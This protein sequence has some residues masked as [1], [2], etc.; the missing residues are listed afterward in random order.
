MQGI[1]RLAPGVS[2]AA[3]TADL[4]RISRQIFPVWQS[5]FQDAE[6][7]LTPVPLRE[8]ILGSAPRQVAL[9]GGAV[10]LL[11]LIAIANVA[12]LMLV[13]ASARQPELA[14]RAALGASRL[15]LARLVLVE[16]LTLAGLAGL[17]GW[18]LA[19]L[20]V[21][22]T[23]LVAPALPRI[24]EAV[25][26]G[27]ALAFAGAAWLASGILIA[28]SP[29]AAVLGGVTGRAALA[30]I[31]R[32][33]GGRRAAGIRGTLVVVEFALALPLLLGAGLLLR[34][35]MGLER[36]DP[37]FDPTGVV[38]AELAPPASRY[39]G[40]DEVGRFW[41]GVEAR[42]GEADGVAAAGLA[43]MLP[44]DDYGNS[45][46]N[47]DLRDRPVPEGSSQPTAPWAAV[48]SGYFRALSIPLLQGRLF[49]EADSAAAPP[50]A[51]VSRAGPV[52]TSRAS[53]C[54]DASSSRAAAG[55]ARPP[56]WWGWSAT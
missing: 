36:V 35:V 47:F 7:R 53:G 55:L 48:T 15:R 23:P 1:A 56:P 46:N 54:S 41:R 5:S 34:T 33:G 26:D 30:D 28:I 21:A 16:C 31:R 27:R 19:R 25:L 6:A 40:Y 8:A 51:V 39:P 29:V 9:F 44:P 52:A 22:L 32:A 11:L 43:T 2:P 13:R 14:L 3:A 18:G 38:T 4:D 37:G 12:T 10:V 49:T 45:I 24:G 50:V 20:G 42:A 17:L